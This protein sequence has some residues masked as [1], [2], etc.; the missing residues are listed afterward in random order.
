M[1][2]ARMINRTLPN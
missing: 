2:L 1:V